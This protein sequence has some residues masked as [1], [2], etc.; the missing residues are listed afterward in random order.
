M[1]KLGD[2]SLEIEST[3]DTFPAGSDKHDNDRFSSARR[4][5]DI[6]NEDEQ[7]MLIETLLVRY[8]EERARLRELEEDDQSVRDDAVD[9]GQG[10]DAAGDDPVS[11]LAAPGRFGLQLDTHTHLQFGDLRSPP[12]EMNDGGAWATSDAGR[13]LEAWDALGLQEH[14]D[15]DLGGAAGLLERQIIPPQVTSAGNTERVEPQIKVSQA[16]VS[17]SLPV[18]TREEPAVS[19]PVVTFRLEGAGGGG[20][21]TSASAIPVTKPSVSN[22]FTV[23]VSSTNT[24]TT[25]FQSPMISLASLE[26][27]DKESRRRR[28]VSEGEEVADRE[29]TSRTGDARLSQAKLLVA[30]RT[31]A[32]ARDLDALVTRV[33]GTAISAPKYVGDEVNRLADKLDKVEELESEVWVLTAAKEG[34]SA[35]SRRMSKWNEWIGRQRE[36]IAKIRDRVWELDRLRDRGGSDGSCRHSR[37]HLEKVKLPMFSG[38]QEEF[39]EFRNQFR[40]LCRG[41]Q[42]TP[43][44]EMAQLKMKLP[45]EAL[46]MIA[47]IQC[48]DAA[49]TKLEELY[50]NRELSIMSALKNLRDFKSSKQA[51][52]EQVIEIAM[53][54]QKC[55]T[56]LDN[57]GA[58]KELLGD[59]EALACVVQSLPTTVRDKWYDKKIPEGTSEKGRFLLTWLEEQRENAIRLR[60]DMMAAR[61][62]GGA[63]ATST[64]KSSP[65]HETTDKGLVSSALHASKSA[66]PADAKVVA[67]PGA[68]KTPAGG[69]SGP[70]TRVEVK[71]AQDAE[72]IAV[73]RKA[74]LEAKKMDKCLV[75]SAQ[76]SYERTWN[77]VQPPVKVKLVSTHLTSC[78]K[79]LALPAEAKLAAVVGNAAC[80][81][82]AAWDHSEH[83]YPGRRESKEPKCSVLVSGTACGGR[84]GRWYHEGAG[85]GAAH[86]VVAAA[87]SQGPGLYEVYHVPVHIPAGEA[88]PRSEEG[89]VMIDPGADT[90][91]I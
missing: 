87:A 86:S 79:F 23:T 58:I 56:E 11:P 14:I 20:A 24:R 28:S 85:S 62:R 38:K 5:R 64:S 65:A 6:M 17:V 88:D 27:R 75:C 44:L 61:M 45:R 55:R 83:K 72:T 37:G 19:T 25:P 43:I 26:G 7:L 51:S 21:I 33:M 48:P 59:R 40:E 81:Q 49:W 16:E 34:R 36:K 42:Y 8:Q 18:S 74:N 46:T 22:S 1:D 91:F 82:C 90:N 31:Q 53:A 80:L 35:Q 89:M 30:T 2:A 13:S 52:H 4:Q 57:I 70:S 47:G 67:K 73:K 9:V 15:G 50:G 63:A 39:L 78:P 71:T 60:L 29:T 68:D 12:A 84:H 69:A 10:L 77:E 41:E 3:L 54:V 32:A 66:E 76:H